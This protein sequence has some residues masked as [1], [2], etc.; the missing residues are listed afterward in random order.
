MLDDEVVGCVTD[1]KRVAVVTVIL[2]HCCLYA[3]FTI[4]GVN[5]TFH[6]EHVM[7]VQVYD[8]K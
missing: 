7:D 6:Y 4:N 1:D 5:A 8:K 2:W 3:I